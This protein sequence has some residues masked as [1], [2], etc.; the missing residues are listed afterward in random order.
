MSAKF[1]VNGKEYDRIE[2]M[3]AEVRSKYQALSGL[4]ADADHNGIPDIMDG[5]GI[6][7]NI[8][9]LN[10]A[11]NI[12][13]DGKVYTSVS[14]LPPELRAKYDKAMQALG[15]AGGSGVAG[16][17]V[18]P[19]NIANIFAAG[20]AAHIFHDGKVF[21]DPSQL[22]PEARERYE[23][24]MKLLGDANQ[25]GIP[26][27]L[28]GAALPQMAGTLSAPSALPASNAPVAPSASQTPGTLS[29]PSGPQ[30]AAVSA[31]PA[32]QSGP[33]A[34]RALRR[35][36]QELDDR[37]AVDAPFGRSGRDRRSNSGSKPLDF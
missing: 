18:M 25:N 26:D 32:A 6:G 7:A 9:A 34:S 17:G 12:V 31:A 27:I 3:P 2:D 22:P 1:V 20:A 19:A 30:A 35:W 13:H 36:G 10:M 21:T 28:E 16:S 15:G 37:G 33:P 24:A 14:D 5:K 8:S 29:A 11:V 4:L 23:K